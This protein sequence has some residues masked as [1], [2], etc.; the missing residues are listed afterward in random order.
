MD[1]IAPIIER[2]VGKTTWLDIAMPPMGG[3]CW[4]LED[5]GIFVLAEGPG[6]LRT[7]ACT[8]GGSGAIEVIDGVPSADGFFDDERMT[9][10]DP[11]KFE[12][13]VAYFD[14]L[15]LWGQRRG[16]PIYK[17]NPVVMGSWM[18]DGGFLHGLTVR[19]EGGTAA[20]AAIASIVWMPFKPRT[21]APS[22]SAAP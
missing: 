14:A 16:R 13:D 9:E 5:K 11:L 6:V 4:V 20:A 8:H 17:A 15:K 21:P 7:I 2:R 10:P 18:L 3:K 19:A 22:T 12:T 1:A